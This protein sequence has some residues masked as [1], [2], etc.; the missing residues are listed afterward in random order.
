VISEFE[1][2]QSLYDFFQL[3]WTH[4]LILMRIKDEQIRRFYE[5]ESVNR[6]TVRQ[7]KRQYNSSLY[8]R[9]ALSRN[10][11][12]VM[13]LAIEGQTLEKPRD[14]LKNPLVLEFLNLDQN[15]AYSELDLE[16]AIIANLQKFLLELAKDFC[17]KQGKSG[18][19][20]TR[21][22]SLLILYSTTACCSVT[23]SLT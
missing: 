22:R 23:F 15:P 20:L 1:S 2:G 14:M 18:S 13:R 11:D 10:K 8:E 19:R 4:Y 21:N 16:S 5:I 12:E 17:S 7:L 9:L 6:R 3:S